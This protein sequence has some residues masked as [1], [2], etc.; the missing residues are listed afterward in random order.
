M[1][2][3]RNG[4]KDEIVAL[5]QSLNENNNFI[6]SQEMDRGGAGSQTDMDKVTSGR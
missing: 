1:E 2:R 4:R 3:R 6:M 5:D